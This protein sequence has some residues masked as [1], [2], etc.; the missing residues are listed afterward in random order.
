MREELPITI[1]ILKVIQYNSCGVNTWSDVEHH[2]K[3]FG[4]RPLMSTCR[5]K[6]ETCHWCKQ[7]S[8]HWKGVSKST[9]WIMSWCWQE[10]TCRRRALMY[11]T[12]TAWN[13]VNDLLE[14]NTFWRHKV[15]EWRSWK[16]EDEGIA[17]DEALTGWWFLNWMTSLEHISKTEMDL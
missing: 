7:A 5:W 15:Q 17:V 11:P 9:S 10:A 16:M 14:V 6:W 1:M 3:Y 4:R 2:T 8:K 12:S 13:E